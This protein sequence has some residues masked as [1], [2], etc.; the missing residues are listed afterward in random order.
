VNEGDGGEGIRWMNFIYTYEIEQQ[1]LLQLFEVG[2]EE[3]KG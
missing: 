2:L 1:N 3:V